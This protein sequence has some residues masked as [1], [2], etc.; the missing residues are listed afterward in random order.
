MLARI[1][2]LAWLLVA[3]APVSATPQELSVACAA[4]FTAALKEI[5]AAYT[6]ATGAPVRLSFGS[7][8]MLYGQVV[9]GAPYDLF[10][11]ADT[12]RPALLHEAGLAEAPLTYAEGRA[13]L[14]TGSKALARHTSWQDV[15]RDPAVLRIAVSQPK[16][17][18]YG[19][20]AMAAV[21]AAGLVSAV[22]HRL[23]YGKSVSQAFQ[24]AAT[25]NA[26]V[27]FCALSQAMSAAGTDG[28]WWEIP[29]AEPVVQDACV[30]TGAAAPAAA[31]AFLDYLRGPAAA[32]VKDA[33]GYD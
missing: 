23:V 29:Q 5:A 30:L 10:L 26:D 9:N 17:A 16:V 21:E 11:A 3:A 33:Y 12:K 20:A 25:G 24:F 14:W 32:T 28:L 13:A 31:R 1:L 18:P 6:A 2:F 19:A 4:N 27:A 8:G 15:V 22:G 7:T